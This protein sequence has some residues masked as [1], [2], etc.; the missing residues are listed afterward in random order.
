MGYFS[1]SIGV[2]EHF[3][4]PG[5]ATMAKYFGGNISLQNISLLPLVWKECFEELALPQW[6]NILVEIFLRWCGGA[7]RVAWPCHSRQMA[8][9]VSRP[10]TAAGWHT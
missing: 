10:A 4:E 1:L 9:V 3:E 2:E 7:F 6:P 5:L 8:Q